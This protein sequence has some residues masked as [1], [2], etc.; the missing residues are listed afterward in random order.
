MYKGKHSPEVR[1]T[2]DKEAC[3]QHDQTPELRFGDVEIREEDL[4][5]S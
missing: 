1:V 5:V 2:Y 4:V 3:V